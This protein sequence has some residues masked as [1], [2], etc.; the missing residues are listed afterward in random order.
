[1][2]RLITAGF[3]TGSTKEFLA[4]PESTANTLTLTNGADV[5]TSKAQNGNYSLAC[6]STQQVLV[7]PKASTD[8]D[9]FFFKFD[10]LYIDV[11]GHIS[12]EIWRDNAPSFGSRASIWMNTSG[13]LIGGVGQLLICLR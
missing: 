2:A 7:N 9:T 11:S 4:S 3:E 10:F 8:G 12:R 13:R 6:L 1:M 5:T